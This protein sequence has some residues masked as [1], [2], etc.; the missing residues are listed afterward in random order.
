MLRIYWIGKTLLDI[1]VFGL[2]N[3]SPFVSAGL[4]GLIALGALFTAAQ[5]SA[6]FIYTLF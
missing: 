6:P 2:V 5:V 3:R 4:L 1:L